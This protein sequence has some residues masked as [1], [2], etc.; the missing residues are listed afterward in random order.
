MELLG[1]CVTLLM[2]GFIIIGALIALKAR[3]SERFTH[4]S[5][6][7][8]LGVM[9]MIAIFDLSHEMYEN[10]ASNFEGAKLYL[11]MFATI[12]IGI[13]LLKILD[14]FIPDHHQDKNEK[15]NLK[16]IGI[17][18]SIALVLHNIIEGMALYNVFLE[19]S[20]AG[21]LL[22]VGVGLHNIPLGMVI[23][24]TFYQNNKSKK[25]TILIATVIAL[26]TFVGGFMMYLL[27]GY[28]NSLFIAIV[29]AL[30]LGMIIYIFIFELFPHLL[31]KEYRKVSCIGLLSG[32]LI[33]CISTLIG[34]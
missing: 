34:H 9:A 6:G 15:N 18:S 5:I 24:S 29:L 20:R 26:S 21:I 27:K 23:A 12:I 1:L 16:H 30:T 2:G 17:I 11:I 13:L 7:L 33:I 31:E 19:S 10:F 8:A 25:K 32:I 14:I 3:N 22:S 28:I 4:F